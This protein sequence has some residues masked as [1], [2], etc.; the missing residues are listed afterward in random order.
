MDGD[1]K[2]WVT[3]WGII[4]CTLSIAIISS[5]GHYTFIHAK[6]I[7]NGYEQTTIPGYSSKVWVKGETK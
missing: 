1:Q 3:V 7:D 6:M 5:V 2:F 4:A